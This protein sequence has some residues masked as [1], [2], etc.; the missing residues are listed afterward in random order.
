MS[1][2]ESIALTD[3]LLNLCKGMNQIYV[4]NSGKVVYEFD[5]FIRITITITITI[6][7]MIIIIFWHLFQLIVLVRILDW[8]KSDYSIK[9]DYLF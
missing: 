5:S 2:L 8:V 4:C 3:S 1:M 7:F 9:L 6:F